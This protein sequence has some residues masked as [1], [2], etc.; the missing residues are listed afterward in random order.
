MDKAERERLRQD[1]QNFI[2]RH[3]Y[4]YPFEANTMISL[5][6]HIDALEQKLIEIEQFDMK[7]M[8]ERCPDCEHPAECISLK[9]CKI[10]PRSKIGEIAKA[11]IAA[12]PEPQGNNAGE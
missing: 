7:C 11:A 5:L 8:Y 3:N 2:G 9:I 10:C 4:Y 1:C 12:A 6:D